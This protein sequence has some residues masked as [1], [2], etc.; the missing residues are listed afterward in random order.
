M[1]RDKANQLAKHLSGRDCLVWVRAMHANLMGCC[2]KDRYGRVNIYINRDLPEYKQYMILLHEIAHAKLHYRF[3]PEYTFEQCEAYIKSGDA[4]GF[5]SWQSRLPVKS[6]NWQ[7]W[8]NRVV[9][10][11]AEYMATVQEWV[12]AGIIPPPAG[13]TGT[14]AAIERIHERQANALA[15]RWYVASVKRSNTTDGR[16]KAL[17]GTYRNWVNT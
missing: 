3:L 7:A 9:D 11:A 15:R 12:D 16:I 8:A 13:W 10:R 4:M 17:M 2:L 5:T 14:V 6:A 1:T